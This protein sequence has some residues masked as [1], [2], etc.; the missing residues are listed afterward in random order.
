MQ[1][2]CVWCNFV[3]ADETYKSQ[4]MLTSQNGTNKIGTE[5][6]AVESL[7]S[8]F[9]VAERS[10]VNNLISPNFSFYVSEADSLP[11]KSIDNF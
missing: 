6:Q 10:S 1:R 5:S 3:A 7:S 8:Q 2:C 11:L 4:F 9:R